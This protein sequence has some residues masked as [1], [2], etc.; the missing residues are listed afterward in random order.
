MGKTQVLP[1]TAEEG[2]P[3][4]MKRQ[5]EEE[6][7]TEKTH[8][9]GSSRLK[10]LVRRSKASAVRGAN[11]A[12]IEVGYK[13]NSIGN[14]DS[15]T[16][17][18]AADF[19]LF[20]KWTDPAL[21][22]H[23]KGHVDLESEFNGR[24]VINPEF[25]IA[26]EHDLQRTHFECKVTD[27]AK[28]KVKLS[29]Y[30]RGT[31]NM[32]EMDLRNFP[33]DFQNLRIC[34]KPH[35]ATIDEIVFVPGADHV[36]DHHARHEWEI[37]GHCTQSYATNPKASTTGKVYSSLHVI[38]LVRRE[39]SWYIWNIALPMWAIV[40]M[41]WSC[42]AMPTDA[43][44]FGIRMETTVALIL[45]IVATKFVV[46]EEIPKVPYQTLCDRYVTTCFF[47]L[48]AMVAE[49]TFVYFVDNQYEGD[50]LWSAE[51]LNIY[52]AASVVVCFLL[53]HLAMALRLR[54]HFIKEKRWAAHA[55]DLHGHEIEYN[56]FF[57]GEDGDIL[58][59]RRVG[60]ALN[61]MKQR[62]SKI[63]LRRNSKDATSEESSGEE[64]E[65]EAAAA[66][67]PAPTLDVT[68]QLSHRRLMTRKESFAGMKSFFVSPERS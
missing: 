20:L 65:E 35:K 55:I 12:R 36:I 1:G 57:L 32:M 9:S 7:K 28:G 18:F 42:F 64:E 68:R 46:A 53:F 26:N 56:D 24:T 48:F 52:F 3:Q 19:K 58:A 13:I 21:E 31:L 11:A 15:K 43:G 30:F 27:P 45:A 39:H 4:T 59:L 66:A 25:Q 29:A 50:R 33:F 16:I 47:F 6:E 41:S 38:G 63:K 51:K 54:R 14:I 44:G 8:S 62:N 60:D 23:P 34:I 67:N 17:T 40:V 61:R 37:I 2:L 49:N 22:G 10:N 5:E